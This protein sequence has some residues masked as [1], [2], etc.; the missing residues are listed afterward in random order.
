M[1]ATAR[2]LGFAFVFIAVLPLGAGAQDKSLKEFVE[3]LKHTDVRVRLAGLSGLASAGAEAV[4]HVE[5]IAKLLKDP[6]VQARRGA[7]Q[8]LIG[9]GAGAEKGAPALA[10]ALKDSDPVVK[11]LA[12]KAL[13]DIGPKSLP[14]LDKALDEKES[15]VRLMAVSAIETIG[16]VDAAA[17]KALAK[18]VRDASTKVRL[19]ALSAISKGAKDAKDIDSKDVLEAVGPALSDKSSEIRAAAAVA[20][21]EFDKAGAVP[22]LL[23]ALKDTTPAVRQTAAQALGTIGEELDM[24]GIL[25]L[26]G[27]LTDDDAKVRQFAAAGIAKAG[28]KA[29]ELGEGKKITA[30]LFKLMADKEVNVRQTAVF[31]LGSVGIDD[32]EEIKKL[33]EGLKDEKASVRAFTVQALAQYSH[34]DAPPDW[35]H[36]V[37]GHVA[38]GI[39]DK[40]KRVMATAAKILTEEKGFAVPALIKLVENAS[41]PPRVV[42]A[43]VLGDIGEAAKE[44]APALRKMS[45]D[46]TS[47]ARQ[48]ALAALVKIMP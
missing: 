18:G 13:T 36:F 41:G 21:L 38:D 16:L 2:L 27:A 1:P 43:Q 6:T 8:V 11:Q 4:P 15:N 12:L 5:A 44:A 30:A 10:A 39:K 40:D 20:L 37:L 22:F 34:D 47:E 25:A 23:K 14:A 7:A 19:A 31:A 9:L 46:G 24:S 17:I 29:R 28:V 48:A 32:K 45:T 42:A 26:R 33:A 3:A 35:R